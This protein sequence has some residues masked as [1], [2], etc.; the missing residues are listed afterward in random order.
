MSAAVSSSRRGYDQSKVGARPAERPVILVDRHDP[1][2]RYQKGKFLGKG[3]FAKCYELT[4]VG[5]NKRWAGK[6]VEKK[7]LIKYRAKEKLTTE[8]KIHRSLDHD[9]IVGFHRFFEDHD[10]VYILLEVCD[11]QTMMEL[12]KRRRVLTEPEVRYYLTQILDATDYMHANAVIHRDLKLGNLFLD[13]DMRIKVGDFGLAT[14]V[15][16]DGERKKTLCGTPNYIAPE[17][18]DRKAG[19]SFPVDVWSIGCIVYTLLCGRPPFETSNIE[20]TYKKIKSNDYRFPS[21][22]NISEDAKKIIQ[23]MLS[24]RPEARPTLSQIREH[25]FMQG[26][27]PTSLPR[28]ALSRRPVFEDEPAVHAAKSLTRRPLGTVNTNSPVRAS[29]KD[30]HAKS[31]ASAPRSSSLTA[32]ASAEAK[33][34]AA[35]ADKRRQIKEESNAA[36][37]E[38]YRA[39]RRTLEKQ[40]SAAPS[41]PPK[42]VPEAEASANVWISKW[43]DYSNK[44][45]L[46]YQLSDGSVGVLFND[47]TKMVLS[48]NQSDIDFVDR[49]ANGATTSK[50]TMTDYPKDMSKKV[51]LLKYF[52]NYMNEHLLNGGNQNGTGAA[53][54]A[55]LVHM[56]KWMRTKTAIVF[57]LSTNVIQINFF[58]HMKIV[59]NVPMGMVTFI[60]LEREI[61]TYRL[62][63]IEKTNTVDANMDDLLSCMS[64]AQEVIAGMCKFK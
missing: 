19:H 33:F 11:C 9:S 47:T 4:E 27:T 17:I 59:L 63:D 24:A 49:D 54:G 39:L 21:H 14:R 43:V 38:V 62:A 48:S 16:Y 29:R 51:T 35:A 7:T 36:I 6:I 57:R 34:A 20:S 23:W 46:G 12:H 40:A 5:N 31:A 52:K 44:Y 8:I 15:T 50:V 10:C 64:F 32:A 2:Y 1:R 60:N 41:A 3:G 13:A 30:S 25:R 18:L 28:S 61:N 56:K 22:V 26:F 45:G 53:P 42:V 37:V 55:T 58:N